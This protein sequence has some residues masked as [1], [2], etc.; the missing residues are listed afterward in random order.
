MHLVMHLFRDY[1]IW[2]LGSLAQSS[3]H[4][5]RKYHIH[6]FSVILKIISQKLIYFLEP[7]HQ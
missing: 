3:I 5:I 4:L 2:K 6:P 7:V 1:F